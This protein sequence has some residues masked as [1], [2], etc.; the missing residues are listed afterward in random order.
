MNAPAPRASVGSSP[1]DAHRKESHL[2]TLSTQ[3][4]VGMPRATLATLM[5]AVFTVSVGFGVVLPLLPDLIERLLGTGVDAAQ[6]SRH[7]G[8]LT[9]VYTFSLF[10]FA[11]MWGRLS[12]RRGAR[13]VLLVGLLGFGASMLIFSFIE[14]LIAV[15]VERFLSGLFAAAVTPVAAA[16][17]GGFTTTEQGRARRLAFVTMASIGGFLLGPMLSVFITHLATEFLNILQ[18]IGSLTIPLAVTALLA[19][20]VALAVA[21][22]VPGREVRDLRNKELIASVEGTARLVPKLLSL[23]F[24]VSAGVGVFEVGLALRGRQELG[25]TPYQIALMFTECSLVMFVIQAIVFSPWFKPDSTRWLI[26][27]ALSVLAASLFLVPWASDF[28]SMLV[29]IGAVAASAGILSPILTYWISAKAGSAQG[30]QLGKQTAAASLGV[31]VGSVAGGLLFNVAA[32]PGAS[33][34]LTAGFVALGFLLSLGLPQLLVPR[35]FGGGAFKS[36]TPL[37]KEPL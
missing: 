1:E 18:P 35:N 30:W 10:L 22:A 11:P 14:S 12:D 32:L 8:L 9:A 2:M 27:P 3:R 37:T 17:V 6:V 34:M 20:L 26:A 28:T 4:P 33:F 24:I 7:T 16:V 25:L 19:A 23:T 31:T 15:Y 36:Q 5:L 29:V 21:F 13:G